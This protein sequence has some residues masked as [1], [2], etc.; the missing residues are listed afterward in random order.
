[1]WTLTICWHLLSFESKWKFNFQ[2]ILY[3]LAKI[4]YNE[5]KNYYYYLVDESNL[6]A[7]NKIYNIELKGQYNGI[8]YEIIESKNI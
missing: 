6:V 7:N 1:M 2:W 4:K 5:D 3:N 8:T